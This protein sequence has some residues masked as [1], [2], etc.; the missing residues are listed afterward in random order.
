MSEWYP[1]ENNTNSDDGIY[2]LP[3]SL[4]IGELP[5]DS[6]VVAQQ[7][8]RSH[9][10]R[11]QVKT[12]GP[13][14]YLAIF[15]GHGGSHDMGPNHVADYAVNHLHERLAYKLSLIDI[16]NENVVMT[17][18]QQTFIDFDRE[19]YRQELEYGSTCTMV[20]IHKE[21]NRIYQVNLGDSR[22][23]IFDEYR[24]FSVTSD[25][26][27][28]NPIEYARIVAAGGMVFQRR[29]N[30]SILVSRSFGDFIYKG[31]ERN[32]YDPINGKMSAVPDITLLNVTYP[33][34]IL[35]S[36]DAPFETS[37]CNRSL[38]RAIQSQLLTSNNP[39][40]IL[41]SLVK[42]ITNSSTDDTTLLMITLQ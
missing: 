16:N 11:Y 10:D 34:Y 14:Q 5:V 9:E 24:L 4:P 12:I 13:F 23:F 22:S 1:D 28:T 15:D 32:E 7:Q 37:F 42:I 29:L 39:S 38:I 8:Q 17:M 33:V 25:H 26:T 30:G 18:I 19:L 36:S 31:T 20:L 35:L 2:I 40:Q 41:S 3:P 27:P 21:Q 6:F